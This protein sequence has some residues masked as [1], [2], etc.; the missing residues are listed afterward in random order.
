MRESKQLL[1]ANGRKKEGLRY[2]KLMW[3]AV[4]EA[5]RR[6]KRRETM[7]QKLRQILSFSLPL[8]FSPSL[9]VSLGL[10]RLSNSLSTTFSLLH[11]SYSLSLSGCLSLQL[12][13]HNAN[14][15]SGPKSRKRVI[16]SFESPVPVQR[17][18]WR[19][20]GEVRAGTEGERGMSR[21]M[22]KTSTSGTSTPLLTR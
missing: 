19:V 4:G 1:P 2:P 8:S 12:S 21:K 3:D 11:H 15:I 18:T 7:P 13:F 14:I 5:S 10:T 17:M 16:E 9:S 22:R 6:T 20:R